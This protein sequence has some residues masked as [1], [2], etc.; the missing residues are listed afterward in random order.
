MTGFYEIRHLQKDYSPQDATSVATVA[1]D[2]LHIQL[3]GIVAIVGG[4]G[5]GKTTL[6]NL[7]SGLEPPDSGN[8]DGKLTLDLCLPGEQI[9]RHLGKSIPLNSA[10]GRFPHN[11]VSYIFQQGYLLNQASI[12]VNLAMTRR[13][14][15]LRADSASLSALLDLAQLNDE[16]QVPPVSKR[17]RANDSSIDSSINLTNREPSLTKSLSD[18]AITLSGGQQQR[19]NIARALGREP[20]L[21]FADELSSS[22]DPHKAR[23][24]MTRI[25]EWIWSGQ[26]PA[27]VSRQTLNR[28]M[29]W[30]THDYQLACEYADAVIVMHNGKLATGSEEPVELHEFYSVSPMHIQTWVKTG[31]IDTRD[32]QTRTLPEMDSY[33]ATSNSAKENNGIVSDRETRSISGFSIACGNAKSGIALSWMEAF[34]QPYPTRSRIVNG[35]KQ[36]V[37]PLFGFAHWV[38]AL[39]L[40]AILALIM[41]VTY[42]RTEVIQY[43]DDQLSDPALSHVIVNQNMREAD[44]SVIN[45]ESL[46]NLSTVISNLDHLVSEGDAGSAEKIQ[47]SAFGRFTENVIVYPEDVDDIKDGYIAEITIGIID[48]EELV[49]AQMPVHMIVPDGGGCHSGVVESAGEVIPYADELAV[50]VSK[51]YIE[52]AFT[53]FGIDLCTKPRLDFYDAGDPRTFNII[54]YVTDPPADGYEYF[55]ALMQIDVWRNWVSLMNK[56]QILNFS[57]A[58]VYFDQQNH[59]GVIGEL[60]N[61]AFAFDQEIIA[62]FERLISTSAQLRNTFVVITW[63]TLAVAATVA[64]G[65]VWSY[66][67]QNAK[68]IAVLR[69]HDAW[70]WPLLIA[71]P[72]QLLLTF[73]YALFYVL[74]GALLW[75]LLVS[76]PAVSLLFSQLTNNSW[77]PGAITWDVVR[78]TL[79]W[80]AGSFIVMIPVGWVCMCLWRLTHRRLAHELRQAY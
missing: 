12:A 9:V 47:R 41:I 74:L 26:K 10:D 62:K 51:R 1:I 42:G 67:A 38:R 23:D 75:N 65:L 8:A 15:G 29:L 80:V 48:R 4:S 19:I 11:K 63:L 16:E 2:S 60:R 78:P 36:I 53:M 45:E 30:V 37:R 61:R 14:A 46:S 39:Q 50:I 70:F 72:F 24:V 28:A 25:R 59:E 55:D 79:A 54:G 27:E 77:I 43:F 13:A 17:T 73:C 71:I 18:R 66:L 22:L 68:S 44:K 20:A 40:G 56:R 58:A 69:A 6:L 7:I 35:I 57:R 32:L 76:A 52:D 33:P 21:L 31:V 34:R 64:A 3:G 49:Y 5:S